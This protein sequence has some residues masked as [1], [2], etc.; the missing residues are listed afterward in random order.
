[1][2][3][4]CIILSPYAKCL[5]SS[6]LKT[7][8]ELFAYISG[9]PHTGIFVFNITSYNKSWVLCE[10]ILPVITKVGCCVRIFYHTKFQGITPEACMTTMFVLLIIGNYEVGRSGNLHLHDD[11]TKFR[12][13]PS[14]DSKVSKFIGYL[15]IYSLLLVLW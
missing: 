2:T 7:E 8:T 15:T 12:V 13:K 10:N 6:C 11:Y 3:H 14:V 4:V 1:M 9:C 5:I